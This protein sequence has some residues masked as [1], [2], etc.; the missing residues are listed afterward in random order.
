MST[1]KRHLCVCVFLGARL[2]NA[3]AMGVRAKASRKGIGLRDAAVPAAGRDLP[4]TGGGVSRRPPTPL[5]RRSL[6]P[7]Q[8]WARRNGQL[9]E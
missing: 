2:V 4:W 6:V 7:R 9:R 1:R 8:A 3:S 5:A